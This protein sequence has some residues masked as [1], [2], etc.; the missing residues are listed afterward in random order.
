MKKNLMTGGFAARSHDWQLWYLSLTIVAS[1]L[2]VGAWTRWFPLEQ[3]STA[4]LGLVALCMIGVP[5]LRR[6]FTAASPVIMSPLAWLLIAVA[7]FGLVSFAVSVHRGVTLQELLKLMGLL[8]MFLFALAFAGSEDRLHTLSWVVFGASAVAMAGS[9]VLYLLSPRV[10]TGPIASL[11]H[12]LVVRDPNGRLSAFFSY[13]N[14]LAGFLILP[15]CIGVGMFAFGRAGRERL[16]GLAG[17]IVLMSALVL[18]GS[19]GGMIVAAG[20]LLLLPAAGWLCKYVSGRQMAHVAV[21]YGVVAVM[22]AVSIAVP[23]SRN[24]IWKPLVQRLV[25]VVQNVSQGQAATDVSLGSRLQMFRD[26]GPYLRAY[27]VLG[28]GLGTYSSVY[29]KFRSQFFFATDP[30]SLVVKTLAEGGILGFVLEFAMIAVLLWMGFRAA[31]LSTNKAL[32]FAV[33]VGIAGTLL[34][35]CFD[36][37]SIFY[38]FGAVCAVLL[39]SCAGL[40]M[41]AGASFWALG[42]PVRRVV[43]PVSGAKHVKSSRPWVPVTGLVVLGLVAVVFILATFAE[44]YWVGGQRALST[45]LAVTVQ[46]EYQAAEVLNPFNARYP[47]ALAGLSAGRLNVVPKDLQPALFDQAKGAYQRAVALDPL[48]PVVQI[49]YAQFLYQH[50]DKDAV[51]VFQR[52]TTVDPIDPGTWTSLAHAQITFN[53]N[54]KLA[55]QV[56]DQARHLDPTYS[57]IANVNSDIANMN[58]KIALDKGDVTAAEA[59]FRQSIKANPAQPAGWSGLANI[60]RTSGQQGKLVAALFDASAS[61]LDGSAF[62]AELQRLAPVAQWTSPATG[63]SVVPGGTVVLAW[64]V[65]GAAGKLEWQTVYA[66]PATGN[67]MLVAD[68]VKPSVRGLT[69]QV[70]TTVPAGSYHFY[71]YLQAPKLMAGSDRTWASS[72]VS[73]PVQV[74]Q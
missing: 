67:S 44:A 34:H 17:T 1:I 13:P 15:I 7:V 31:R 24:Q 10:A 14:A 72:A 18:T 40:T 46:D 62:S 37:D 60:Y 36:I 54:T 25:A 74:G 6:R 9:I 3:L 5:W 29:M 53:H 22:A 38:V 71:V 11:A 61:V 16:L 57:E 35:S 73:L 66:V 21:A 42:R 41:Q 26:L 48:N 51:E 47:L 50:G 2:L 45:T 28:S 32:T 65:T 39:G 59:A 63:T 52:L 56:L 49:Q 64:N 70:P 69:W 12:A 58:A 30:H 19:R 43:G 23:V 33:V 27:P 68:G 55:E 20:V 4:W 8:G